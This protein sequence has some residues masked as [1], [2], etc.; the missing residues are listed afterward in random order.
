MVNWAITPAPAGNIKKKRRSN[1]HARTAFHLKVSSIFSCLLKKK[2]VSAHMP[3]CFIR[4]NWISWS[5]VVSN[6]R[7]CWAGQLFDRLKT[8]GGTLILKNLLMLWEIMP[9]EQLA[10]AA[11]ARKKG[12]KCPSAPCCSVFW[13]KPLR[14][15]FICWN[16]RR[17][18]FTLI[19]DASGNGNELP[20]SVG[21]V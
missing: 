8:L 9:S 7:R 10:V 16:C 13:M 5:S 6:C 2:K 17:W 14:I 15:H 12:L 11:S 21:L 1:F 18:V 4:E 19:W 20:A 3:V